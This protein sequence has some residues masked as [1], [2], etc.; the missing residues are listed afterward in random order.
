MAAVTSVAECA[1]FA[2]AQKWVS[3][4][5]RKTPLHEAE[6][7][8]KRPKMILGRQAH[9]RLSIELAKWSIERFGFLEREFS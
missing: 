5:Q 9:W 6:A 8:S 7:F 4:A 2:T 3:R 1:L